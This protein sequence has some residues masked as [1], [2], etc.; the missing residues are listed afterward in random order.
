MC[1]YLCMHVI[2]VVSAARYTEGFFVVRPNAVFCVGAY[3]ARGAQ[4][5]CLPCLRNSGVSKLDAAR[6]RSLD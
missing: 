3:H 1:I 5:D 2:I 6:R 4:A